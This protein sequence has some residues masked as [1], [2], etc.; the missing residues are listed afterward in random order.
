MTYD[1]LWSKVTVIAILMFCIC[2]LKALNNYNDHKLF[3]EVALKYFLTK[4]IT[5]FVKNKVSFP[6]REHWYFEDLT[7]NSTFNPLKLSQI[8]NWHENYLTVT[9][10]SLKDIPLAGM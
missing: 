6:P 9:H 2:C 8:R 1:H 10:N 4:D 3:V 7:G 5:W